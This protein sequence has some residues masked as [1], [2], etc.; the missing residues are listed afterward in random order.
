MML[1]NKMFI[2]IDCFVPA[3]GSGL[4]PPQVSSCRVE[5][6]SSGTA[7]VPTGD[8]LAITPNKT[9]PSSRSLRR[10]SHTLARPHVTS[11][12]SSE[13]ESGLVTKLVRINATKRLMLVG[14]HTLLFISLSLSSLWVNIV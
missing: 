11:S 9:P 10:K 4:T 3:A 6:D 2:F 8:L 13:S 5:G 14:I 7:D 12:S 1:I